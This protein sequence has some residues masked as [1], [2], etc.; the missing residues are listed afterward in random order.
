M[1]ILSGPL[2]NHHLNAPEDGTGNTAD[3]WGRSRRTRVSLM[4]MFALFGTGM[5]GRSVAERRTFSL[6]LNKTILTIR[7]QRE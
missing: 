7:A 1:R 4:G 6:F 5:K 3:D 2:V